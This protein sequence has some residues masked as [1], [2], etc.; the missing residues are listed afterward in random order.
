[1]RGLVLAAGRGSRLGIATESIPKA[2]VPVGGRP[3]IRWQLEA[4][5]AADIHPIA[6]V[7]GYRGERLPQHL[8]AFDNPAW[9][10][11]TQVASLACARSWLEREP[12]IVTYSDLLLSL[13]HI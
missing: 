3:L 5:A 2:L 10:E 4:I 6:V 9:A 12:C 11:S 8:E 1:M 13:I 7:R